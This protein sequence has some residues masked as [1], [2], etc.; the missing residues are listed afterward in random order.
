MALRPGGMTS[1]SDF[2]E[3][4]LCVGLRIHTG[5][6]LGPVQPGLGSGRGLSNQT[7][8]LPEPASDVGLLLP[9]PRCPG[10][11]VASDSGG[12]LPRR[13]LSTALGAV[14]DDTVASGLP[15]SS[16]DRQVK[17]PSLPGHLAR[18]CG[19]SAA[20][21]RERTSKVLCLQGGSGLETRPELEG[22]EPQ[23]FY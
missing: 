15:Q 14:S 18:P 17:N 12:R 20:Q 6:A 5:D 8:L 11:Q 3:R 9:P 7:W 21:D 22:P 13:S 23:N 16:E 4:T 19:P 1:P 2:L 10:E